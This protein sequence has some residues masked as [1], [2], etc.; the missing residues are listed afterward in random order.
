M[1]NIRTDYKGVIYAHKGLVTFKLRAGDE[2]PA[3][4]SVDASLLGA[5]PK[6]EKA[7]SVFPGD[8][9]T[10]AELDAYAKGIGVNPKL[11]KTKADL[12]EA[13]K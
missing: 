6:P 8:D 1:A 2:V 4:V 13:L 9:A 7:E 5:Q 11:F 3:G 10:R 12:I